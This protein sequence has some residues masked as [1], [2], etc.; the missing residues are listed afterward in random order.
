MDQGMRHKLRQ[1][2]MK[3][4]GYSTK[5]VQDS[6]QNITIGIGRNLTVRGIYPTEV[7]IM[8]N[9]DADFFYG[10]LHETFEWYGLLN[11]ARQIALIDICFIGWHQFLLLEKLIAAL[12]IGDYD[13]AAC[14]V[15]RTLYC[16]IVSSRAN[17]I[18]YIIKTGSLDSPHSQ[19]PACAMLGALEEF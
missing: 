9:H 4:E 5:L 14:E 13:E 15:I 11:E 17:E 8:F 1:L 3:H 6:D 7:D 12:S 19:I 2:V 18:S 10:K 16:K